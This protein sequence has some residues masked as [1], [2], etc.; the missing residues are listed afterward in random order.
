MFEVE[1]ILVALIRISVQINAFSPKLIHLYHNIVS[2]EPSS[3][4]VELKSAVD[5]TANTEIPIAVTSIQLDDISWPSS[6]F[7]LK[8]DFDDGEIEVL[9]SAQH[10]FYDK[11]VQNLIL[12]YNS[13]INDQTTKQNIINHIKIDMKQKLVYI[14]H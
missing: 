7:L 1:P 2:D 14:F 10:L 5:V 6:I 4:T 9:R 13:V 8:I 12:Y 11:R 3:S